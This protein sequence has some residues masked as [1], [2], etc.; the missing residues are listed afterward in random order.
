MSRRSSTIP[1]SAAEWAAEAKEREL[2]KVALQ[3]IKAESKAAERAARGAVDV[4]A[5]R[6][7]HR[8]GA[9]TYLDHEQLL[10]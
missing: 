3:H 1:T 10:L 8:S 6:Q 5:V 4:D 2:E 9:E 7:E